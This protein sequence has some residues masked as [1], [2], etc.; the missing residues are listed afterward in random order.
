VLDEDLG[1]I[2]FLMHLHVPLMEA[3]QIFQNLLLDECY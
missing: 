1:L 2:R 3:G